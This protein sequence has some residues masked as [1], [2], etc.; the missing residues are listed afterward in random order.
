MF[1][2]ELLDDKFEPI[3]F[4]FEEY[5]K[6]T[7]GIT[8]TD[9]EPIVVELSFTPMQ[10]KYLKT[11]KMHPTQEELLDNES[12]YKISIKV[13]PSWE[14][15]EKILGYGDSVRILSPD[16]VIQSFKEKVQQISSRYL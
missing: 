16:A 15:Y 9:E 10:G 1:N 4:N 14:F 5:F 2:V 13:K 7:F 12:E 6:H 11:L 8:V 3:G